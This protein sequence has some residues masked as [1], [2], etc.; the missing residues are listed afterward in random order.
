MSLPTP[1]SLVGQT[2]LVTGGGTGIGL[3]TAQCLADCGARVIVAGRREPEL[4]AAVKSIGA[5]ASYQVLNVA[6]TASHPGL[7]QKLREQH[8]PVGILINNAGINLKKPFAETTDAELLSVLQTNV[9]GANALTH[10]LL[11]Q[12][13]ESGRGSVVFISSMAALFGL[14]RV[15]AYSISKSALTGAMRSLAVELGGQNIRVN[16]VAPGWIETE[17]TRKAFANDPA[18]KQKIL[19]RT[20]LGLM[21]EPADIG[22]AVA[23]LCSPAAKFVTGTI[24]TVDGGASIGF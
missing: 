16:A 13:I 7:A 19:D 11:P 2:A 20:P 24:L 1:Y 3:A 23:Y 18:R 15:T 17:M 12:L 5:N 6:D 21:G 22:W 9:V 8:G 4:A 10:A 14:P